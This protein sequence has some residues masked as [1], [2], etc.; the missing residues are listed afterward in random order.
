MRNRAKCKKC[1]EVIESFHRYDYV[2]CKCREIGISGGLDEYHVA[3][4]DFTNFLRIDDEGQTVEVMIKDGETVEETSGVEKTFSK[5]ELVHMLNE[6]RKKIED[7]PVDALY[8]PITHAD[9]A[10]LLIMLIAIF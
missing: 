5:K 1:E 9:Y 8:L 3:A 2:Y 6:M 4:N 10:T 7:L